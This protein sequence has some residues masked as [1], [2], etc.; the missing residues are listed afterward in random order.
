MSNSN[1]KTNYKNPS[2]NPE[3]SPS[4]K[5]PFFLLKDVRGKL[6]TSLKQRARLLLLRLGQSQN[7]LADQCN[8]THGT[9][10]MIINGHW[11]AS[12]QIKLAMARALEVDSL[13]LFGDAQYFEDYSKTLNYFKEGED[14]AS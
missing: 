1:N 5:K 12:S 6:D 4:K 8:V 3:V 2:L 13:V 10:S 14:G 9:M 7:W 11:G